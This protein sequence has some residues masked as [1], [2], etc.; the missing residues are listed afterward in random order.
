MTPNMLREKP[1]R[2]A[3]E[4]SARGYTAK[5]DP[6][7]R[8]LSTSKQQAL[9]QDLNIFAGFKTYHHLSEVSQHARKADGSLKTWQEFR[10][11][12]ANIDDKYNKNWLKSEYAFVQA[13]AQMAAKWERFAKWGDAYDLLYKTAGDER[14]RADHARLEG[15]CLPFSDP[16]W[17]VCYPPNGWGCRCDVIQVIPGSHPRSDSDE[18]IEALEEMTEG[19]QE[20]FRFNPGKQGRLTPPKHPYYGK[21]GYDHCT[22]K[23]GKLAGNLEPDEECKILQN[24]IKD[25]GYIPTK[26]VIEKTQN[27]NT[28][29]L[30]D[31]VDTTK[32]D[33]KQ[34]L[35]SA[36]FFVKNEEKVEILPNLQRGEKSFEYKTI[37]ADL[38]G[39]EYEGKCPDLRCTKN[40]VSVYREV[41]GYSNSTNGK[42][43]LK[44]MLNR[45]LEQSSRVVIQRHPDWTD[46]FVK[47]TIA[48]RIRNGEKINEVWIQGGETEDI[49]IIY[50]KTEG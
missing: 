42:R 13:S 32:A 5:V 17:D 44:N 50:K 26:T 15:M 49:R 3:I 25:K 33:Y 35:A 38:I 46:N 20:I 8:D 18:M 19:K 7:I 39:T 36:R 37:Y 21:R 28:I 14:V 16:A 11:D 41:K 9:R 34:I 45:A 40:G 2:K 12:T 27:G 22:T 6:I 47:K 10:D 24:L 43:A 48:N 23:K 30:Y 29:E 31:N 4:V 1:I